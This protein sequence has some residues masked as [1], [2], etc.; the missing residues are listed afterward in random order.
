LAELESERRL[1]EAG[2]FRVLLLLADPGIGKTRLA[3]EFLARDRRRTIGLSARAFPL[4]ASA[5]FGVWSEAFEHHFRGLP[6]ED[7]VLL[8]GGYLDDLAAL[9]HSVAAARGAAP[10]R[11]PPRG[12]LLQGLAAALSNLA[13]RAPVVVL[14]DDVHV[15]DASSWEALSYLARALPQ[16]RVLVLLAARPTELTDNAEAML[17]VHGLEQDGVLRRLRIDPLDGDALND[18]AEKLDPRRFVRV[19][20]SALINIES[21][22][23]LEPI[24]HGEFEVVLKNASRTRVSRTYRSQLEKRLGQ[25]L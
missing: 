14:L 23:Q 20:R 25:P 7:V 18:L 11:E 4:G 6:S 10:A 5:S 2:E 16:S 12:R 9:L 17:A 19:H 1:A 24:S 22:V 3:R 13:A 15:A 8:C 21:V